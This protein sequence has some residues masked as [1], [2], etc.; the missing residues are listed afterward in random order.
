M[1]LLQQLLRSAEFLRIHKILL[2]PGL[3]GVP[4]AVRVH[5]D[6]TPALLTCLEITLTTK[7]STRREAQLLSR[8]L[9]D[10]R[11]SMHVPLPALYHQL[12]HPYAL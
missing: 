10:V 6:G 4:G 11:S 12:G 5:S 7:R 8:S 9:Q 1:W 2:L 3:E